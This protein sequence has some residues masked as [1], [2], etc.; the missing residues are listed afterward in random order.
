VEV[1]HLKSGTLNSM[2]EHD[3]T[4]I[5][6]AMEQQTISIAKV[7]LIYKII[8][9]CLV[10]IYQ[11]ALWFSTVTFFYSRLDL[12]QHS[13]QGLLSLVLQIQKGNTILMKVMLLQIK[14]LYNLITSVK[15]YQKS[16]LCRHIYFWILLWP[17]VLLGYCL[18]FKST[19]EL[20]FIV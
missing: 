19:G 18:F 5:H 7:L 20:C 9:Y 8:S 6:E 14:Q 10:H 2:R 15:H 16:A 13:V 17:V 12:W 4:T 1:W 3:R 11:C